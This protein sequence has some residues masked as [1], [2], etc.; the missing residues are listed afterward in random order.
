MSC[1]WGGKTK[2]TEEEA[3]LRAIRG[4]LESHLHAQPKDKLWA[5]QLAKLKEAE[6]TQSF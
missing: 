4:V 6:A 1:V 5:K 2:R 3:I